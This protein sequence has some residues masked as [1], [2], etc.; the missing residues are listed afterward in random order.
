[1]ERL[2]EGDT[3]MYREADGTPGCYGQRYKVLGMDPSDGSISLMIV[4]GIPDALG[5][6][7]RSFNPERYH[8]IDEE[9]SES[10][11]SGS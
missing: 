5:M 11:Q 7:Y 10:D 8:R 3:V 9:E 1:M 2:R 4:G 6:I